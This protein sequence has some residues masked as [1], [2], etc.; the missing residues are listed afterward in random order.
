M[1]NESVSQLEQTIAELR[2]QQV[3][4]TQLIDALNVLTQE[5]LN[6]DVQRALLTAKE[7]HVLSQLLRYPIGTTTSLTH[8]SWLH[9]QDGTFDAAVIEAHEALF[10][11]ESIRDYVLTVKAM[12]TVASAQRN[13]GNF[14]KA[15]AYW[16]KMLHLARVHS[17]N[18]RES[19][20]LLELSRQYLERG[21]YQHA[22][23]HALQIHQLFLK[24]NDTRLAIVKNNV[25]FAMIKLGNSSDAV[26]WAMDALAIC[27]PDWQV[28]RAEF[29]HTLGV[30]QLSLRQYDLA[31]T[32]LSES[33]AISQTSA[34]RI[35][36]AAEVLMELAK[37]EIAHNRITGAFNKLDQALTLATAIKA[38]ALQAEAHHALSRLY[39]IAHERTGADE[40]FEHYL[41]YRRSIESERMEKR[42]NLFRIE[43][44]VERRQVLWAQESLR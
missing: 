23:D 27:D 44:E 28:W 2:S 37:L 15:E 35:Y 22:L 7:A 30:A 18:I 17:D 43:A 1:S 10:Y 26:A 33:L 39:S 20:Y 32:S 29:L 11:A 42:I 16:L 4:S 21:D 3:P 34:G 31:Q 9:L 38:V 19:D 12:F 40:H 25:A 14:K 36:T 8:L 6:V 13:A 41:H 24:L 5:L